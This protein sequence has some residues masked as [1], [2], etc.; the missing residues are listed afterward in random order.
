MTGR[1]RVRAAMR[2]ERPDRVPVQ[3]YYA[4][5]G[6]HE[7]GD[8][9]NDLYTTL[10]GDFEPFRR[11][12]VPKPPEGTASA[13][14]TYR[15]LR[16]DDWGTVWAYR[17][18][19]VAGIPKEYP[20]P[21]LEEADAYVPPAR[22]AHGVAALRAQVQAHQQAHYKLHGA[23]TL[24]ERLR[25]LLP[26]EE[27][28][29]G[30][31]AQ[32]ERLDR[33][34]DKVVAYHMEDVRLAVAT[35]ADGIAF[36]DDY[37]T[38]RGMIMHPDTWRT[39]FKPRLARLFAPAVEAGLDIVF[40]S[41]GQIMDILGDLRDIGV[42]AVWPQLP[43]YD[44]Q[45]LADSCRKLGLAVAV[46]TDRAN[47]MTFGTPMDV[48]CLVQKE[49]EVFRMDGGGAWFYVEADNGFPFDNIRALVDTIAELRGG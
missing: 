33:L 22:S 15:E 19:G 3:Y 48:R 41:C 23:G 4:P 29:C 36:G 16:R 10:P 27:V 46:H 49:Y 1:G 21:T 30:L 9:L 42:T 44:M 28:L 24:L 47:A 14:G 31:A 25:S 5:V 17:I 13:D 43:A 7:H 12:P 40:H 11:V 6:Y 34:A 26:D 32:D 38:E 2:F 18:F 20:I 37:G 45:T 39:F 35:G 8:K